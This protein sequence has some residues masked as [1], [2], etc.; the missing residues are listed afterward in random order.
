[1]GRHV[2]SARTVPIPVVAAPARPRV[3]DERY[4]SI[5]RT[6]NALLAANLTVLIGFLFLTVWVFI[7][8]G[9]DRLPGFLIVAFA[10][11]CWRRRK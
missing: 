9:P 2:D 1:M 6:L 11:Y 7:A 3:R 8:L 10:I 5:L 4:S